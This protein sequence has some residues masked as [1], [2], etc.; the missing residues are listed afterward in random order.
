MGNTVKVESGCIL[1]IPFHVEENVTFDV[2]FCSIR[3]EI[4]RKDEVFTQEVENALN[5]FVLDFFE[6]IVE[7]FDCFWIYWAGTVITRTLLN[8][9]KRLMMRSRAFSA[10]FRE[11]YLYAESL[12]G[13][14]KILRE[15]SFVM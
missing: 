4:D 15:V 14:K 12:N 8:C 1:Y 13:L 7:I 5:C 3:F 11:S 10:S 2:S 6:L 9:G